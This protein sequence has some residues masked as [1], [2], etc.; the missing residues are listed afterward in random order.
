MRIAI[1]EDSK[2]DQERLSNAIADWANARMVQI[3]ILVYGN[4]EEFLF[5]WPD[6]AFDLIFADIQMCNMSGIDMAKRIREH[7]NDILIVFVTSFS[8]YSLDGYDV[9]ALHYLIKPLSNTKLIPILDKAHFVWRSFRKESLVISD[10]KSKSKL[11]FGSIY[12]ISMEN[13]TAEIHTSDAVH[14]LRRTATELDA[15]LPDY[16]VRSHRSYIVNLLRV[17]CVYKDSVML[18]NGKTLP[19]SRNN[20]KRINDAFLRLNMG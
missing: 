4:A 17:D 16:F 1:V 7:D 10:G 6:I 14:E 3:E 19:V 5:A 20:T 12:Y 15:L 9:N 8:Q 11:L 18:S 2:A 13:H